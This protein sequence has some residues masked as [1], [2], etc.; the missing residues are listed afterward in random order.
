MDF[1][2]EQLIQEVER[3]IGLLASSTTVPLRL[4]TTGRDITLEQQGNEYRLMLYKIKDDTL[5]KNG[6]SQVLY[7]N[8]SKWH[9]F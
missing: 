4:S 6:P 2:I 7:Q 5:G 9:N 8:K 3:Q 1:A